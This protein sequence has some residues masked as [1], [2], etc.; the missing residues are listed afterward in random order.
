MPYIDW[1][2][3]ETDFYGSGNDDYSGFN[4]TEIE[5]EEVENDK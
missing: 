4:D 3:S 2:G 5:E 1:S